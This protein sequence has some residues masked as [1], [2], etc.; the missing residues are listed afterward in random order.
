[1]PIRIKTLRNDINAFF[2]YRLILYVPKSVIVLI[3][4]RRG[5]AILETLPYNFFPKMK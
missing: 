2:S 3:I 5:V 1:M 4:I